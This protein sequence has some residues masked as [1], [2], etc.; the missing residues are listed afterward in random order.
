MAEPIVNKAPVITKSGQRLEKLRIFVGFDYREELAYE[1][2]RHSLLKHTTVA[3]EIIPLKLQNLTKQG[4]Y[5]RPRDPTESTEFSFTRFL[6]PYLAGFEGW[7]MFVD[8]DFLYTA[9]V[10]ELA[11]LLHEQYAIM[12]VHHNYTPKTTVKMDGVLQT[13]YPRKNWSSMVFYNCAHSKNKLLTPELVNSAS[14]AFLHRFMWLEDGDIGELP[15]TWNFLVGH[16][17]HIPK[18]GA[19]AA[20]PKAIHFTSGGPWFEAWQDCEFADVWLKER[21]EYCITKSCSKTI[22]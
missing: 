2:C 7:A 3:L 16:N 15:F 1:V 8:C 11:E 13:S 10:R 9:D 17:E 21:D 22:S 19:T 14:G 12:C 4:I 6:T 20:L 18:E 5:T